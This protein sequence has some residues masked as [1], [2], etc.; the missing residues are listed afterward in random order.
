[1]TN[2]FKCYNYFNVIYINYT[3]YVYRF[4]E[5][6]HKYG[7]EKLNE[8]QTICRLIAF[9]AFDVLSDAFWREMHDQF[10]VQAIKLGVFINKEK[11]M[12]RY[13]Y[14]GDIFLTY[15]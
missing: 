6:I 1:M 7:M 8:D 9:E 14:H 5:I 15:K 13:L 4:R 12:R 2:L 3:I 11:D 10:G